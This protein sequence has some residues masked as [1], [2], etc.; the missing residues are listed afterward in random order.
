MAKTVMYTAV[1]ATISIL[2][3]TVIALDAEAKTFT[4]NGPMFLKGVGLTFQQDNAKVGS[5]VMV[6][7]ILDSKDF[8]VFYLVADKVNSQFSIGVCTASDKIIKISALQK[9][10]VKFNTADLVCSYQV[11][12]LNGEISANLQANEDKPTKMKKDEINCVPTEDGEFCGRVHGSTVGVS[13][14]SEGTIFGHSFVGGIGDISK[15]NEK[16]TA[17]TTP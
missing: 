8:S 12:N 6:A 16:I 13:A 10:S 2:L 9:A 11:G 4:T 15:V 14:D 7:P 17:W 1:I 5:L 3:F